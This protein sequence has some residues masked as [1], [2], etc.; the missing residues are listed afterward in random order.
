MQ[1]RDALRNTASRSS[2][3]D[4]LFGWGIINAYNA[5]N[6]F[7]LP[8]ELVS[9]NVYHKKDFVV[10]NWIT[11]TEKNNMG[12]DI[13][14]SANGL[15][16]EKIGFVPGSGTSSENNIYT[17]NDAAPLQFS[18]WYRLRQVDYDGTFS[19]SQAVNV[20]PIVI[21]EFSLAQN[22]PNPFNPVTKIKFAVPEAISGSLVQLKVY[23]MLGKEA[24]VL[25][26]EQRTSGEYEVEFNG[27]NLSSGVYFYTLTAGSFSATR[28]LILMK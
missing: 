27:S 28:K 26:N 3:P 20:E 9:F 24:A 7:P 23:D 1:V 10:L 25:V 13:E 14:R 17:F 8:V 12:F 4:N 21:T 11:A 2:N 6:Y 18:A 22:Y 15:E 16:W 5:A 19:Y